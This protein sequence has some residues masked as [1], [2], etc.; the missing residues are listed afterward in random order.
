MFKAINIF[1]TKPSMV[2]SHT[3]LG[4]A[5]MTYMADAV[6]LAFKWFLP[7]LFLIICDL[8]SGIHCAKYRN[9]DIHF[10]QAMRRTGNKLLVYLCW[11]VFAV[12]AGMLYESNRFIAFA[13]SI[14]IFIE[15]GSCVSNLLE[16]RGLML[17]WKAVMKWIGTKF[18]L[19]D[20]SDI[21]EKK[22]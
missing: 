7:I 9:E 8:A 22:K 14:I 20:M 17:N 15:G 2:F 10:S 4:M 21:I 5:C 3:L 19:G 13:M 18:N 6:E 11:V 1:L 16:P 12:T